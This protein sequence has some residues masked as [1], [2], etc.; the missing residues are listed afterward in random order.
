MTHWPKSITCFMRNFQPQNHN[1]RCCVWTYIGI[2]QGSWSS[3]GLQSL[4]LQALIK[5][6]CYHFG[7]EI[8]RCQEVLIGKTMAKT[9]PRRK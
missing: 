7:A 2:P 3:S 5:S 9:S 1:Q 4:N 6:V 8:V